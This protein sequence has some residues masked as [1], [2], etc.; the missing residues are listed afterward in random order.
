MK[1]EMEEGADP[2]NATKPEQDKS[3]ESPE[4]FP[5]A[6]ALKNNPLLAQVG[7]RPAGGQCYEN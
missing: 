1:M 2:K 5:S 3:D 6:E 4:T 7:R